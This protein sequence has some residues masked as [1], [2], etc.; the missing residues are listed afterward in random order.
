MTTLND[1]TWKNVNDHVAENGSISQDI[2]SDIEI[3]N[4]D[5]LS[6]LYITTGNSN[7]TVTLT[8]SSDNRV[9]NIKKVDSGTGHIIFI[10]NIDGDTN[11]R[12][13][14]KNSNLT[15]K[16]DLNDSVWRIL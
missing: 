3:V 1:V 13:T 16:Y 9:L 6:T 4:G 8:T 10:G 2:V 5:K 7:V 11:F 14:E 15:I 12:I